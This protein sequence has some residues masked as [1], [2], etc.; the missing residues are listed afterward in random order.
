M[1]LESGVK[2]D[3]AEQDRCLSK[4]SYAVGANF[5]SNEREN[6]PYCLSDTR[7]EILSQI[8]EWSADPRH[9]SIFWLNGMAGTGKSTIARTIARTLTEQKRL[10]ANFFFSR[11]RGDLS[12]AG[13][14][15]STIA[16][17]LAATSPTLKHYICEAISENSDVI[18]Q[19]MRDQ[20]TQLIY[21]PLS[22]LEGDSQSLLIIVFVFDALDECGP[23]DD[24]R[25]LIQLL[26]ET[27]HLV[28][29]QFRALVTSRPEIPIRLGF[30]AISENLHE[31]FVLHNIAPPVVQHDIEIFLRHEINIIRDEHLLPSD[32]PINEKFDLL[33]ERCVGLFI[34]AAT[35]CRFIH[36]PK[37]LP[38]ER[39][40]IVLQGSAEQLPEQELDEMYIQ[41]LKSS[42]FGDCNEK[43]KEVL[44]QRFRSTVGS[45]IILFDSLSNNVL[46]SLLPRLSTT[47][48]ITLKPLKSLLDIPEDQRTPIRILHPSFRDFLVNQERCRDRDFW[49]DQNTAHHD[50]AQQCLHLMSKSLKRNMCE[51]E[52]P[53]TPRSEIGSAILHKLLP[54]PL[55][56]ACQ[57]WVGHLQKGVLNTYDISEVYVFLQ[58]H[59][60]HWL[61]ALS[62]MGKTSETIVLINMLESVTKVGV[63]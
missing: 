50:V 43:E 32:W 30:R 48:D 1:I 59:F 54:S 34:Y 16:V 26:A 25:K 58:A 18:R 14:L 44:S 31:D 4:L 62:L 63:I 12:H 8:L 20:W 10:A 2:L 49:I 29:V 57:Y 22:R 55:Q 52:T 9:K 40:D 56:Y 15:L 27:K 39:L 19:S 38:I 36:D 47:V 46:K 61:E 51:L 17:Q 7:V 3:L 6:E 24:I 45:I 33:V 5:D 35:V 23:Q 37:W 11:G 42:V 21:K 13:K 41:I 53:G 28:A 60:L